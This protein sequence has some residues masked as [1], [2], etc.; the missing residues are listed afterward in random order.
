MMRLRSIATLF[1]LALAAP[2]AAQAA[3]QLR[4]GL[5]DDP[6]SLDP[7]QNWTYVGRHVLQSMC[8]KLVDIDANLN[9]VPML[10]T[11]WHWSDDAKTL[12]LTLRD[13]VKFQDGTPFDAAAV[14]FSLERELTMPGSRRKSEI[15]VIQSVDATGP[16]SVTIH[17]AKPS[18][19]LLAAF[20]DRPGMMVSPKAATE[21]GAQFAQHPVCVGPYRFVERVVQDHIT[22]ERDP[23]HWR[24]KDYAFDRIV[25]V[26]ITDTSVRLT[27]L[28]SGQLDLIEQVL[29]TDMAQ[30]KADK[31]LQ[32]FEETG[33][34][35]S[36]M[37]FNVANGAKADN[38]AGKS[39][40]V[41][42]AIS[43]AI[44]RD[45]INQVAFDG[46]FLA[47]NQP[48]PPGSPYYDAAF[49]VPKRDLAG[50]RAALASA[51]VGP[52][53]LELI[54]PTDPVR[55]QI[56][57]MI[58]AMLAEAGITVNLVQSEFVTLLD[59]ARRGD[60]QADLLAWSGRV[61]PD[62]NIA[63][64]LGCG[65]AGNDGHYCSQGLEAALA[66]ARATPDPA[67]RK[68]AY[69]KAVAVLQ[70]DLPIVYLYHTLWLYAAK[71]KLQGFKPLPDGIMRLDG[72]SM[73][74]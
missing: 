25:F 19:P 31:T 27:N 72:V 38:P 32:G 37:T 48:F 11:E 39:A 69:A 8:D 68:P 46:R 29:P 5:Q 18:V 10:A 36:G 43:L 67:V 57:Q 28:R 55:A 65:A 17:L 34:G 51:G 6:D 44:D 63:P 61:D 42:K 15:E 49:P 4:I 20:A 59:R 3:S 7:A 71:A 58:Q 33:L 30:V 47:G 56:G 66:T 21:A 2:S 13:H 53:T 74:P 52:V 35:Y 16:L 60:F 9:L 45:A 22:L 24:A 1:L 23:D 73:S 41:R 12:T 26:P 54:I 64:L 40:A 70:N 62:L 50:A 14:K